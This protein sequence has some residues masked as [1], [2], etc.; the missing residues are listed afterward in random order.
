MSD[1]CPTDRRK[2]GLGIA[3]ALE[4]SRG[5]T[6]ADSMGADY[7]LTDVLRFFRAQCQIADV[8][9]ARNLDG[10]DRTKL[11]KLTG[12]PA[13]DAEV[14]LAMAEISRHRRP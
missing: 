9:A 14:D 8:A 6:G 13:H 1:L 12:H 2:E 11:M 10:L 4:I 3:D 5:R 7:P